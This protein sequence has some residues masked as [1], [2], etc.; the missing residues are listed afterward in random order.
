MSSSA[1]EFHIRPHLGVGSSDKLS[2]AKV[3]RSSPPPLRGCDLIGLSS[4]LSRSAA[5]ALSFSNGDGLK[6]AQ[7]E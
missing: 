3:N 1:E 2:A 4:F 7:D 5:A 6:I